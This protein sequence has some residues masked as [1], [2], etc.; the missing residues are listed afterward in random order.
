MSVTLTSAAV[1]KLGIWKSDIIKGVFK[2][3]TSR[4]LALEFIMV[5][6]S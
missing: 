4:D 6:R 1:M 2:S 3:V 5:K